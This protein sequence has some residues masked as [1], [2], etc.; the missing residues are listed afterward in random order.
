VSA[1][2]DERQL[3]DLAAGL[4]GRHVLD[5]LLGL[6]REGLPREL[7][8]LRAAVAR[9]DREEVRVAAHAMG[10]AAAMF[11][12]ARLADVCVEVELHGEAGDLAGA[13]AR[14]DR[15]VALVGE[16]DAALGAR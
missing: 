12:A 2:L 1:P 5:E 10:S 14:L 4:G 13:A 7:E 11:G 9:G 15:L 8:R 6:Y 3:G 16:V